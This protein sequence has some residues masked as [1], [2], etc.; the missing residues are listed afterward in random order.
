[1][2]SPGDWY[3]GSWSAGGRVKETGSGIAGGEETTKDEEAET[4]E[5]FDSREGLLLLC[6]DG[7]G[8]GVKEAE[9]REGV[10]VDGGAWWW[11]WW[12]RW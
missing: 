4:E 7:A 9:G 12:R 6:E 11:W 5:W 10:G 1:M 2:P 3:A 8:G